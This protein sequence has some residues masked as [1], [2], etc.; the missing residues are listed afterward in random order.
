[1]T[2]CFDASGVLQSIWWKGERGT[3]SAMRRD[4]GT[5]RLAVKEGCAWR[6]GN[7]AEAKQW[8]AVIRSGLERDPY[9]NK[10]LVFLPIATG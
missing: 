8:D 9:K 5:F 10:G 1:M 6:W 3:F 4:D 7:A 2:Y